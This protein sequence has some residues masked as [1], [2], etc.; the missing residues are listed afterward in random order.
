MSWRTKQSQWLDSS[1]NTTWAT[2]LERKAS[3]RETALESC[4]PSSLLLF[5]SSLA[6]GS[7]ISIVG[8][9]FF[10]Y[11]FKV[12]T[13]P[14]FNLIPSSVHSSRQNS[15]Q[16]QSPG[17]LLS[18]GRPSPWLW[19]GGQSRKFYY[20]NV[21][22]FIAFI[23]DSVLAFHLLNSV[24]CASVF[25]LEFVFHFESCLAIYAIPPSLSLQP[26]D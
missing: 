15:C 3:E 16:E 2:L 20:R 24:S 6:F 17:P 13:S 4:C 19:Y 21:H 23:R 14:S 18:N 8:N 1:S 7:D 10:T 9:L 22:L 11:Y 26:K 12:L 25:H 5:F